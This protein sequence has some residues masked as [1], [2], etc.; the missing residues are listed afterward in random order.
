MSCEFSPVSGGD[1]NVGLDLGLPLLDHGALLV[2]GELHTVEVGE[3]V[4]ALDLLADESEL[5]VGALV[6]VEI[7][8]VDLVDSASETI[9]GEL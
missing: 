9:S 1:V 4:V 6:T 3:A 5:L 7:S 8:L 2:S